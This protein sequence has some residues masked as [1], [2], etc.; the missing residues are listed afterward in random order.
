MTT[1]EQ[2]ELF[3]WAAKGDAD[4]ADFLLAI[5]DAAHAWDDVV[6]AD[7]PLDRGALSAAFHALV[8]EIPANPFYR[9]H[10]ASIDPLIQ[11]AAVNWLVATGIERD[12]KA[13]KHVGYIL[14][15]TYID[16]ITHAALLTG[17]PLWAQ[18][19]CRRVRELNQDETFD[20]YLNELTAEARARTGE[21]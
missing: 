15:S 11:Q 9:T 20:D 6:D 5:T 16:L 4:A 19:V 2:I 1:D 18:L 13:P 14:R 8:L 17:G 12:P 3:R 21:G 7:K 10:R